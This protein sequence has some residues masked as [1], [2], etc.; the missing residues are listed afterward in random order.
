M[1]LLILGPAGSGK[2]TQA[3]LLVEKFGFTNISTGEL[4]RKEM[5]EKS[6]EGGELEAFMNTG[7]LVPDE[8]V[9]RILRKHL[10]KINLDKIILNGAVRT[11]E[12][13]PMMDETLTQLNQ[14][15]D[16]VIHFDLSLDEA[17][18]RLSLRWY[19]P[20]NGKTYH[21]IY[22]P[23][24]VAGVDDET[25]EPLVK[26]DDDKEDAIKVRF[27]EYNRNI[28]PILKAYEERGILNRINAAPSID[29]IHKEVVAKLNL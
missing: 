25:G 1:I 6:I 26:R 20:S 12:Q 7:Q 3:E 27:D 9:Y 2:D 19:S 11:P 17:L 28:E 14:K 15:L 21:E 23:P 8:L 24:K 29:E 10:G 22:N 16:R 5:K 4:F 13:I 18:K